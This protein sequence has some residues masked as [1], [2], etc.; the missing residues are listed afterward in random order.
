MVQQRCIPRA[1]KES[2]ETLRESAK[3]HSRDYEVSA[4]VH[5]K[6]NDEISRDVPAGSEGVC[7]ST[8]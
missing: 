4:K 6:D 1:V 8:L 3:V 2:A 5:F 7:K